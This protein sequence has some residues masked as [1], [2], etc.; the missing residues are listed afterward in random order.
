MMYKNMGTHDHIREFSDA[1]LND[2]KPAGLLTL[3]DQ[4]G[5]PTVKGM[6]DL[7]GKKIIM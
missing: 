7:A 4:D 2:V 5:T 3:L 1:I 6:D